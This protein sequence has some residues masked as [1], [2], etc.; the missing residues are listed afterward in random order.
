LEERTSLFN[1][2]E[3]CAQLSLL[4]VVTGMKEELIDP[5]GKGSGHDPINV[6]FLTTC[7][8][9]QLQTSFYRNFQKKIP[10]TFTT[11]L[12]C[13]KLHFSAFFE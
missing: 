10:D 6:S 5:D 9:S 1:A 8:V 13:L 11:F 4:G 12:F 3:S 7:I 2:Q